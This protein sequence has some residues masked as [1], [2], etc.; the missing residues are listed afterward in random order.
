MNCRRYAV[1]KPNVLIMEQMSILH[2]CWLSQLAYFRSFRRY[3]GEDKVNVDAI[4]LRESHNLP[5]RTK[6]LH[7]VG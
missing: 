4:S 1:H 6:E 2:H 7:A 5:D 3:T